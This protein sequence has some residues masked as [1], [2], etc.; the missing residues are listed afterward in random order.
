LFSGSYKLSV[1]IFI[2][3]DEVELFMGTNKAGKH[4]FQMLDLSMHLTK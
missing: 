4:A 1:S 3:Q 2:E